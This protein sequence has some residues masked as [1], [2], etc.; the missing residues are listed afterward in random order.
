MTALSY[1]LTILMTQQREKGRVTRTRKVAA[2]VSRKAQRLGLSSQ[3]PGR[4]RS[5]RSA[6]NLVYA[7]NYI[8]YCKCDFF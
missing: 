8:K 5:R 3:N 2:R 4:S 1:S 6:L 7:V